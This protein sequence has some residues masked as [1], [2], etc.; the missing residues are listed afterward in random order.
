METIKNYASTNKSSIKTVE[1]NSYNN[2]LKIS[3]L[4]TDASSAMKLNNQNDIETLDIEGIDIKGID[5]YKASFDVKNRV[6]GLGKIE[7][8]ANDP[9]FLNNNDKQAIKDLIKKDNPNMTDIEIEN[10]LK[11]LMK[12]CSDYS[13]DNGCGGY[14]LY[15][16]LKE[17]FGKD[18]S[19]RNFFGHTLLNSLGSE[20]WYE[21]MNNKQEGKQSGPITSDEMMKILDYYGYSD[22]YEDLGNYKASDFKDGNNLTD[23]GQKLLNHLKSGKPVIMMLG[24]NNNELDFGY[25][26]STFVLD[27]DKNIL[28]KIYDKINNKNTDENFN[29][30]FN[31]IIKLLKGKNDSTWAS[32]SHYVLLTGADENNNVKIIDSRNFDVEN[33]DLGHLRQSDYEKLLTYVSSSSKE[34]ERHSNYA[35]GLLIK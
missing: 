19:I 22:S 30:T 5:P 16:V 27:E 20:K 7:E 9:D 4:N 2:L 14:S 25:F 23:L 6:N 21:I 17:W 24:K 18:I 29:M 26:K 8:L 32:T 15:V 34:G 11:K 35:S 33:I 10:E 12:A 13:I 3:S 1:I 28:Q 31:K